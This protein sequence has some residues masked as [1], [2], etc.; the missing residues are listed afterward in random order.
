MLRKFIN[1][2]AIN[3]LRIDLN[4]E[5]LNEMYDWQR[6][7]YSSPF[8]FFIKKEALNSINTI[9]SNWFE[10]CY[11]KSNYTDYLSKIAENIFVLSDNENSNENKNRLNKTNIIEIKEIQEIENKI[12]HVSKKNKNIFVFIHSNSSP[13]IKNYTYHQSLSSQIETNNRKN[14]FEEQF[15]TFITKIIKFENITLVIDDFDILDFD[16]KKYLMDN[17]KFNIVCNYLIIKT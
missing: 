6:N 8:P 7:S 4:S 15:D 17:L 3:L 1:K 13:K 12:S 10:I 5:G 14:I 11:E 9:N 2:L 16:K